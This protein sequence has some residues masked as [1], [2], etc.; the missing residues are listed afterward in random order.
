MQFRVGEIELAKKEKPTVFT[1][2]EI[3]YPNNHVD[4]AQKQYITELPLVGISQYANREELANPNGLQCTS[5]MDWGIWH[6]RVNRD[7]TW[8]F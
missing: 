1:G 6:G 8:E 3:F 4:V 7:Q 2:L 5:D